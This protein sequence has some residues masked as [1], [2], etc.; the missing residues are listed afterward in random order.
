MS[1]LADRLR[2]WLGA[3][4]PSRLRVLAGPAFAA[5]LFA[6]ALAF[7]QVPG[8][9]PVA[10]EPPP[11]HPVAAPVAAPAADPHAA[12]VAAPVAAGV[13]A[14]HEGAHQSAAPGAHSA[15]GHE[16]AGH[17]GAGHEGGHEGA[18]GHGPGKFNFAD[19]PRF[20]A[21]KDAASKGEPVVPV[22][23]YAYLLVNFA[24]LVYLYVRMG[25]KPVQDGLDARR[26][27]VAKELEEAAQIKAEA[28]ERLAEYK[29]KL[30]HLDQ[31]LARIRE[32]LIKTGE[33]DRDRLVK[34]AEEKAERMKKDAQFLLDQEV[35]Q[36]RNELLA[37]TVDIAAAAAQKA[38]EGKITAADHDRIANEYLDALGKSDKSASAGGVS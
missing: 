15:A 36:L 10:A 28:S 35:K 12:P 2:R 32:E 24:L 8:Q 11:A 29:E 13:A 23:P 27:T 17:Q 7:A 18:G 19:L 25:K 37:H 16:G 6:P 21:E 3:R 14:G 1:A 26:A 4:R 5:A 20:T 31:E 30:G 9:A 38:L 34:E 22:T 33:A